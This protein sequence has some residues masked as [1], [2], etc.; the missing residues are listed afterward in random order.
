MVEAE[1]IVEVTVILILKE[2]LVLIHKK[3]KFY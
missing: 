1:V 3:K 2:S